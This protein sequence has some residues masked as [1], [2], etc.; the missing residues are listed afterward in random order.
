MSVA[1]LENYELHAYNTFAVSACA[2]YFCAVHNVDELRHALAVATQLDVPVLVMGGGSNLLFVQDF[3]GLVIH[4]AM[5]GIQTSCVEEP[6]VIVTAEAG[7]NWHHFVTYCLQQGYFGLENLALIPG[8]VGAAPVQNIGAYGVE[9]KD[10]FVELT[11]LLIDSGEIVSM[12]LQQCRFGYRDSIF[13]QELKNRAV[14]LSVSFRLSREPCANIAYGSLQTALA[15]HAQP[16]RP[17]D[18]FAAV[19]AIRRSRLPDPT[20]LG[21]AG[22]FFKNPIISV[23]DYALLLDKYPDL[24]SYPVH[25]ESSSDTSSKHGIENRELI[26]IPA[27]WLIEKS[28]WKG[29]R[30]GAVGVHTE[31]ALVLVNHGGGSGHQ[32]LDLATRISESVAAAFGIKLE[33]EVRVL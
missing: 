10:F 21:N 7:D 13:K 27:A 20:V 25:S 31:Q 33:P 26:K 19:C 18:V 11:A 29:K 14:I 28:G 2:R 17:A 1:I 5:Q 32:L 24:P 4:M 16:I 9:L 23:A 3:P 22:S 6:S 30:L 8:N 15:N 12:N